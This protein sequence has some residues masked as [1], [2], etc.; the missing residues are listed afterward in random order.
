[1]CIYM[2]I[3]IYIYTH[4]RTYNRLFHAEAREE[5]TGLRWQS[6]LTENIDN[7]YNNNK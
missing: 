2:C 3:Y 5:H 7:N 6:K 1:M 4:I